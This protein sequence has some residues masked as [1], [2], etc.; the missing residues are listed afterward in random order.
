[1]ERDLEMEAKLREANGHLVFMAK[2]Y[3]TQIASQRY[4][5]HEHPKSAKSRKMQRIRRLWGGK[6]VFSTVTHQ[7]ETRLASRDKSPAMKPT[8]FKSSAWHLINTLNIQCRNCEKVPSQRHRHVQLIG[9]RG[10]KAREYPIRLCEKIVEGIQRPRGL[11][12]QQ[13]VG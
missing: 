2:I 8:R 6:G 9:S 12:R 3:R 13:H 11:S 7:C 1:M 5:L 10:K 4:F